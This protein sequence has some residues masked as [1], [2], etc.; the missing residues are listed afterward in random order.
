MNNPDMENW[1]RNYFYFCFAEMEGEVSNKQAS[2][3]NGTEQDNKK[4]R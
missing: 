3:W 1:K 4:P 2:I